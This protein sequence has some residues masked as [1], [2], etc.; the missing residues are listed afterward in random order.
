MGLTTVYISHDLSLLQYTCDRIAIMYLGNI[1]EIGPTEQIIN[2]PQHPYTK[3]LISAVPVPDPTYPNPPLR[4]REGVPR[5][6]E[7]LQG[8]PFAARCPEAMQACLSIFP[9]LV[10]T[11]ETHH[12]LCHLYGEHASSPKLDEMEK[13]V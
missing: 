8:C 4:I 12:T 2:N 3:A 10:T 6:T 7:M 13:A 11:A 5:P 9:P 1:V